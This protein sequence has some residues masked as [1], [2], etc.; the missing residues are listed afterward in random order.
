MTAPETTKK[1]PECGN[2]ALARFS[3]MN[4]KYCPDCYCWMVWKLEPGQKPLIGPSRDR[5][6]G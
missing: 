2:T 6:E 1:C 3:S 5:K 4:L